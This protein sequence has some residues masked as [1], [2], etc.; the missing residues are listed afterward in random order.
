MRE[1]ERES[2]PNTYRAKDR[3]ESA[4]DRE[5]ERERD[6]QTPGPPPRIRY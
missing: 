4:R 5:K 1:G 3:K 6:S 2:D